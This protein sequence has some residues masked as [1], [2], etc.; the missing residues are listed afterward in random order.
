MISIQ[1]LGMQIL[2]DNPKKFYIFGGS[3]YG[4]KNKY[5]E[6]LSKLFGPVIECESVEAILDQMHRKQI[7]PM[8]KGVYIV[9]YDEAFVSSLDAKSSD[10]IDRTKVPG[11][12]VCLYE[13][14]KHVAKCDKYLPDYTATID[15]VDLK[16]V[17]RYLHEDF[18]K[19]DDRS[20]QVAA[21]SATSY[22]HARCIC[23]VM[24]Y[25][26]PEDL[27]RLSESKLSSLFGCDS[28]SNET[29][30]KLAIG[31]KNFKKLL[32]CAETYAEDLDRILYTILQTMIELDKVKSSKYIDSILGQFGSKWTR[33]DIYYMFMHTYGELSKLRSMSGYSV[34]DSLIYLFSIVTFQR[35]PSLE[36]LQ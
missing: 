36:V 20:I 30:L 35:I 23:S 9:R 29:E 1:D 19:L 18:P 15:Q 8:D 28:Y 27:A 7:I 6:H 21:M 10:Y 5:I 13:N 25:A 22:G 24:S 4:I 16:F 11:V 17:V 34:E 2:K 14:P 26:K 32:K 12:V 3:E 33:E 31:S